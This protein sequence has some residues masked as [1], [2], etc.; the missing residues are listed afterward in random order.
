MRAAAAGSGFEFVDLVEVL[1]RLRPIRSSTGVL[2]SIPGYADGYSHFSVAGNAWAA[3]Q[4]QRR[5][6]EIPSF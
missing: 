3:E 6:M 1:R 5:L 2:G 4:L